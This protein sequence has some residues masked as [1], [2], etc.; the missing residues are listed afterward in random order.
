MSCFNLTTVSQGAREQARHAVTAAVERL[1]QG[2]TE[3]REVVVTP[4]VSSA[5]H[6]GRVGLTGVRRGA[7]RERGRRQAAG[8]TRP[9]S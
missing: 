2:R 8:R 6:H 3:A 1:D 7:P 5:A 9:Y 4:P